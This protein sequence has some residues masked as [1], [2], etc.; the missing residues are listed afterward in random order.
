M[1]NK[2]QHKR[3]AGAKFA[4]YDDC[5]KHIACGVTDCRGELLFECLPHGKYFVKET[6][7]PFGFE[8]SEE[9]AEVVICGKNSHKTVEFFN[10]RKT[11]SICV[12]KK[13]V[14]CK[15]RHDEDC[16]CECGGKG[17][18]GGHGGGGRG[19]GRGEN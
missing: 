14:E 6:D 2:E 16:D 17:S 1:Q 7:A 18:G 15:G 9:V 10:K 19:S 5:G 11:G 3:L 8:K 13:G 12:I 4:L